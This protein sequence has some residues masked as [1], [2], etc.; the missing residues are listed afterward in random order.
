MY[1]PIILLELTYYSLNFES[2]KAKKKDE[3]QQSKLTLLFSPI[4]SLHRRVSYWILINFL[5]P[6]VD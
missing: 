5:Q 3:I 2:D 1:F 4:S 6:A